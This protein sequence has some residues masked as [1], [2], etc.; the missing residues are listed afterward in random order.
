LYSVSIEYRYDEEL[1]IAYPFYKF[2]AKL[3]NSAG[4]NIEAV[5]ITPAVETANKD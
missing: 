3:I 1:K 4:I 5:I 2:K